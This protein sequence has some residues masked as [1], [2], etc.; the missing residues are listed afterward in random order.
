MDKIIEEGKLECKITNDEI[1]SLKMKLKQLNGD[2]ISVEQE[3]DELYKKKE[4]LELQLKAAEQTIV[5][6][7]NE[8]KQLESDLEV[9][10]NIIGHR[11]QQSNLQ[12]KTK[13]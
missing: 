12:S 13:S 4:T 10:I 5:T 3:V 9:L 8:Q 6:Y 11:K 7:E 2:Q 1:N